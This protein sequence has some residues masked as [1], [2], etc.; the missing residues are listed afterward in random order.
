MIQALITGATGFVGSSVARVLLKHGC[1][2]RALVRPDS[3]TRAIAGLD[4]QC[5]AGDLRDIESLHAAVQGCDQVYHV[6][7]LYTYWTRN[8]AEIYATNVVGT[9]NMLIAARQA[10][11]PRFVY[12]SSVAV[13]GLHED[14]SPADEETPAS[15]FDMISDYKR[16]KYLAEALAREFASRAFNVV[17]V[18]PSTPVGP[19]DVKP[20]PTGQIVLDYLTGRMPAYV[21]TGLN[22]VDV[23]DVALGHWLAAQ[24]GV[25]GRRYILGNRNLTLQEIFQILE[26][27]SGRPAPRMRLP[28]SMAM[29][30][31]YLDSGLGRLLPHHVPRATPDTVRLSKKHMY[32][33]SSRAVKELGFPQNDIRIAL[34]KAVNWFQSEY[35]RNA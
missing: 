3:D 24:K 19:R 13:L 5:V 29:L 35:A 21:D 4:V 33:D 14:G 31:A 23:E 9:R 10:K 34:R 22:L 8:P 28:H 32:F 20:T 7:A 1:Q 12:T 15:L 26:Q 27:I 30:Y 16:S 2:V 25:S 11:V 17:I 18:N 6:A